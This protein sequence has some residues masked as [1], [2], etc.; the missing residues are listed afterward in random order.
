MEELRYT[1]ARILHTA[2]NLITGDRA[3]QHGPFAAQ[4]QMAADF[5]T[6]YISNIVITRPEFKLTVQD[7]A[8]M[9]SLMKK[10]RKVYGKIKEDDWVDDIGY[11]ALGAAA[12][13]GEKK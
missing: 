9:M 3:E 8:E 1:S 10:T 2:E 5:W 4:F 12:V 6:V 7:V 13:L 11:T